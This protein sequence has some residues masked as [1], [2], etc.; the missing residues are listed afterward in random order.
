MNT[1]TLQLITRQWLLIGLLSFSLGLVQVY[2]LLKKET[3]AGAYAKLTSLGF[4][5]IILGLMSVGKGLSSLSWF[6]GLQQ[7]S[8]FT[9]FIRTALGLII[10][11]IC[12]LG[13]TGMIASVKFKA[14]RV[15]LFSALLVVLS[16]ILYV[17]KADLLTNYHLPRSKS[18]LVECLEQADRPGVYFNCQKAAP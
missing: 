10:S 3:R 4:V 14:P 5:F 6:V 11:L 18:I 13:L 16:M 7:H 12:L 15:G 17:N 2:L 9:T 8:L 1:E